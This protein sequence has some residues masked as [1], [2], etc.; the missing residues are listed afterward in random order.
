[1]TRSM[2]NFSPSARMPVTAVAMMTHRANRM[3]ASRDE[4]NARCHACQK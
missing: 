4:K 3:N 1:M 2:P